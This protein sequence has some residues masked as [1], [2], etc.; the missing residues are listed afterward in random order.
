MIIEI[1]KS[2]KPVMVPKLDE[3]DFYSKFEIGMPFRTGDGNNMSP[4]KQTFE[5]K[6]EPL[7]EA[8]TLL[9]S[10]IKKVEDNND[11]LKPLTQLRSSQSAILTLHDIKS[12]VEMGSGDKSRDGGALS[13]GGGK[14]NLL[15]VQVP[16]EEKVVIVTLNYTSPTT[17][18]DRHSRSWGMEDIVDNVPGFWKLHD[19]FDVT[20]GEAGILTFLEKSISLR[21]YGKN[22]RTFVRI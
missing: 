3:S 21:Y 16:T 18:V 2:K 9:G 1:P 19:V 10:D 7:Q 11:L 12:L 6:E 22:I 13:E 20:D 17:E 4:F 5:G 8:H 15:F 14:T